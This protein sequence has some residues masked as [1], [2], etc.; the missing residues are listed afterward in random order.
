MLQQ[1]RLYIEHLVPTDNIL[2]LFTLK[3][4]E[5][6]RLLDGLSMRFNDNSKV[7][8]LSGLTHMS[9]MYM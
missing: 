9:R 7:D 2:M 4:G 8:L 6:P 1:I 3:L 5:K